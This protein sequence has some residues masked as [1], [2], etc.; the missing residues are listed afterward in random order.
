MME[1]G[2]ASE[3]QKASESIGKVRKGVK[4]GRQLCIDIAAVGEISDAIDVLN[5]WVEIHHASAIT[6]LP[7]P[8]TSC[9]AA[10]APLP[11]SCRLLS[12]ST[13]KS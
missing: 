13:Q 1:G 6:R 3:L 7:R 9:L 8:L 11:K 12:I 5:G 10:S 2:A 4:A